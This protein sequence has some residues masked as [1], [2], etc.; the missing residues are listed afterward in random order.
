MGL[1]ALLGCSGAGEGD[2]ARSGTAT[3]EVT[4]PAREATTSSEPPGPTCVALTATEVAT[5]L[6][7]AIDQVDAPGNGDDGGACQHVVGPWRVVATTQPLDALDAVVDR[8]PAELM[9]DDEGTAVPGVTIPSS[10]SVMPER[11]GLHRA[12]A[13]LLDDETVYRVSVLDTTADGADVERTRQAAAALAR[14]IAS[15]L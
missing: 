10:V 8:D 13:W 14:G 6:G 5:A 11:G 12:Q 9:D 4:D 2:D 1:I 7:V 15:G 3:T